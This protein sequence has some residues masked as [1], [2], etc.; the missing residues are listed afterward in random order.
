MTARHSTLFTI[1]SGQSGLESY[2]TQRKAARVFA[3]VGIAAR[4]SSGGNSRDSFL[5]W[6]FGSA[7][8]AHATTSVSLL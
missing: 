6:C 5:A 7:L 8:F 4:K 2:T 1:G 3:Y